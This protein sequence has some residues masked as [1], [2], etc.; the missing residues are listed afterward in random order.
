MFPVAGFRIK[1]K[2]AGGSTT[3]KTFLNFFK[4]SVASVVLTRWTIPLLPVRRI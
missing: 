2:R 1:M 3:A 4:D